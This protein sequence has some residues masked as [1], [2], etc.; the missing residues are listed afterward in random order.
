MAPISP[1][2]PYLALVCSLGIISLQ[3]LT[4]SPPSSS[5]GTP[6][7]ARSGVRGVQ[8]PFRARVGYPRERCVRSEASK[9][10]GVKKG[11]RSKGGGSRQKEG[12][13]GSQRRPVKKV[14]DKD[15]KQTSQIGFWD[16][17][18]E[19]EMRQL[20]GDDWQE[21][22]KSESA[23]N[24]VQQ[25]PTSSEFV[26]P[27]VIPSYGPLRLGV[28]PVLAD[29]HS[30]IGNITLKRCIG[31]MQEILTFAKN[32]GTS[33]PLI[34]LLDEVLATLHTT[35]DGFEVLNYLYAENENKEV[36][37]Y[38]LDELKA[39]EQEIRLNPDLAEGVERELNSKRDILTPEELI[40]SQK[41]INDYKGSSYAMPLDR[42]RKTQALLPTLG[43]LS[44]QYNSNIQEHNKTVTFPSDIATFLPTT[45]QSVLR[46]YLGLQEGQPFPKGQN[47]T[48]PANN[49][50]AAGFLRT[51]P[52]PMLRKE[53]YLKY[54]SISENLQILNKI[55][56]TRY[57][58]AKLYGHETY[59]DLAMENSILSGPEEA[60][61]LLESISERLYPKAQSQIKILENF[62]RQ[63]EGG[64][65]TI[66]DWDVEYYLSKAIGT[67]SNL[68]FEKVREYFP[69]DIAVDGVRYVSERLFGVDIVDTTKQGFEEGDIWDVS[70]VRLNV[71]SKKNESLGYIYLDLFERSGKPTE[72][73]TLRARARYERM[74]QSPKPE[75][76]VARVVLATSFTPSMQQGG[77]SL[78]SHEDL[79][80]LFHEFGH[81]L[82]EVL[83]ETETYSAAGCF[84]VHSQSDF[85][86][87]P[88]VMMERFAW[89]PRVLGTFATH[90]QTRAPPADKLLTD[91]AASRNAFAAIKAQE[92]TAFG[93]L[94]QEYH[95]HWEN[96]ETK[97]GGSKSTEVLRRVFD[98]HFPVKMENNPIGGSWETKWTHLIDTTYAGSYYTYILA[99]IVTAN[100]WN[101]FFAED[102]LNAESGRKYREAIL[103]S[104]SRDDPRQLLKGLLGDDFLSPDSW[105][106]GLGC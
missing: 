78:L 80:V 4:P 5:L 18:D 1:A 92:K 96:E 12:A 83:S 91:L 100:I 70:V 46:F 77:V 82:N 102:P 99:E 50:F 79:R 16:Q 29:S 63:T 31:Y 33:K 38:S 95:S 75:N 19:E 98:K 10:F 61:S 28:S 39:F 81:C 101:R 26:N 35:L 86:E 34:R 64:D 30:V 58:L 97:E 106:E 88:A 62:K 94:D 47:M 54:E 17:A 69:I 45:H 2:V 20:I 13:K 103:A 74:N 9:G 56:Q 68:D 48:L 55:L 43:I 42:Q 8:V 66:R 52:Y 71:R 6:H 72:A 37:P 25:P 105:L 41:W 27:H 11:S 90:Y 87:I 93:I 57:S 53:M 3:T 7:V 51:V 21:K 32:Q 14:E 36:L 24:I 67:M 59:A 73:L 23:S 40:A 85:V 76:N 44:S 60:K 89:D 22:L 84:G 104:G 15:H 49:F 65:S